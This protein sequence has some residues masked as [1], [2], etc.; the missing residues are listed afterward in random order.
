MCEAECERRTFGPGR[1][2]PSAGSRLEPT[3]AR[4]VVLVQP[5]TAILVQSFPPMSIR[6]T[7]VESTGMPW[8]TPGNTISFREHMART[9]R[10][11]VQKSAGFGLLGIA[12]SQLSGTPNSVSIRVDQG[13][14]GAPV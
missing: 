13:V 3:S 4:L 8:K 1:V 2:R 11:F 9:R 5:G 10:D 14:T 6:L 7:L 12:G